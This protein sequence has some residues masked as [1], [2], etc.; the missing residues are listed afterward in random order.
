MHFLKMRI[1]CIPI[2]LVEHYTTS[3][4]QLYYLII[5]T[6]LEMPLVYVFKMIRLVSR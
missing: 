5:L 3:Y 4:A 6:V 1:N 2:C